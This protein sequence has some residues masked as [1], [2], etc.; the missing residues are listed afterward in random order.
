M[1]FYCVRRK[2]AHVFLTE[3]VAIQNLLQQRETAKE[4]LPLLSMIS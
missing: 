2:S 3:L 1:M 4:R